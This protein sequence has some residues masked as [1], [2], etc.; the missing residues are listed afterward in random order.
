MQQTAIEAP[1]DSL[2]AVIER[3]EDSSVYAEPK[4]SLMTSLRH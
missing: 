4:R 1:P 3:T 2:F